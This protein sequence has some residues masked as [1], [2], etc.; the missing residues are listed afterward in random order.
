MVNGLAWTS[1]GGEVMLVEA[2][3]MQGNKRMTLTGKLGEVM[4]E[5]AQ[6]HCRMSGLEL[7]TGSWTRVFSMSWICIFTCRLGPLPRMARPPE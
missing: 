7:G 3:K 2:T 5:S 1:A 4:R 6:Y